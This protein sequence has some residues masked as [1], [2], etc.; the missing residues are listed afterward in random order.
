MLAQ[1]RG[2]RASAWC[3]VS[4]DSPLL[5]GAYVMKRRYLS[6][7]H[8]IYKYIITGT[9]HGRVRETRHVPIWACSRAKFGERMADVTRT[10]GA[11]DVWEGVAILT[12]VLGAD[13]VGVRGGGCIV[14]AWAGR[15]TL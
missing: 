11:G 1:E 6:L 9:I 15:I 10:W 3:P 5:L 4:R 14:E 7:H 8:A 2:A 13:R 12:G